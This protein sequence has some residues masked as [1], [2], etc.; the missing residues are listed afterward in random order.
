MTVSRPQDGRRSDRRIL[1]DDENVLV[2]QLAWRDNVK[3]FILMDRE[4]ALEVS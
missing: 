2:A 4:K 1:A 3:R